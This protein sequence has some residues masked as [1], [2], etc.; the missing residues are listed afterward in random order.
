M[1]QAGSEDA[2]WINVLQ[3]VVPV[4]ACAWALAGIFR[5]QVAKPSLL[6]RH[7]APPLAPAG[8]A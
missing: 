1:I 5:Q 7:A 2:A 3:Y 6:R 4:A 8:A